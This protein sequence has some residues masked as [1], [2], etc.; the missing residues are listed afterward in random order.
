ML[1]DIY[2]IIS[3]NITNLQ[4]IF[5]QNKVLYLIIIIVKKTPRIEIL[6]MAKKTTNV[7]LQTNLNFLIES[8]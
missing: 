2:L 5:K 1:I 3:I 8:I 4:L 6:A 7:R